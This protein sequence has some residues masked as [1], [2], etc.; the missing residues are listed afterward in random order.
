[1]CEKWSG[2]QYFVMFKA[3]N[4]VT[5]VTLLSSQN[6]VVVT[7]RGPRFYQRGFQPCIISKFSEKPMKLK[8]IGPWGALCSS[9][10]LGCANIF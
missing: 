7:V 4:N 8:H 2:N 3:K 9:Y 6:F 1:M 5:A 10:H